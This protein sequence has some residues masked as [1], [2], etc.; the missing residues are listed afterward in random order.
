LEWQVRRHRVPRSFSDRCRKIQRGI[1]RSVSQ[2][3]TDSSEF[4]DT[5]N[6]DPKPYRWV[7]SADEILTLIKRFS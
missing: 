5:R 3:E 2:L 6:E 7:K 1:H 4:I